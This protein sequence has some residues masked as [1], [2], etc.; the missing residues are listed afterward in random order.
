MDPHP[1]LVPTT[2][3]RPPATQQRTIQVVSDARE[4]CDWWCTRWPF[5]EE[6]RQTSFDKPA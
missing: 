5:G 3:G 1:F 6:W 4:A 2:E